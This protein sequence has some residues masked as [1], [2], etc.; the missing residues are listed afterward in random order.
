MT[1]SKGKKNDLN[2]DLA[3]SSNSSTTN[4]LAHLPLG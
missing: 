4:V 1:N 2:S 3:P